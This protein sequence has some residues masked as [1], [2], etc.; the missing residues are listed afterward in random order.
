MRTKVN[1]VLITIFSLSLSLF[2]L[3]TT[4]FGEYPAMVQRGIPLLFAVTL[5][6]LINPLNQNKPLGLSELIPI[7]GA[8]VALG[9]VVVFYEDIGN[10]IGLTTTF[11]TITSIVG[12]IV[13]LEVARR[14]T[15]KILPSLAIVFI[16]YAIFGDLIPGFWGHS[17][18][19]LE[20]IARYIW[21][22]GD[23]VFGVPMEVVVA[24]VIIFV[25][26]AAFLEQSGAG[27]FFIRLS[28]AITGRLRSGPAMSAVAASSLFGTISGSAVANVAATGVFTIPLMKK[29][30]YDP[31]FA[32]ATEAAASTGGQLMP[33][34]MGAGAFVMAEITGT[35]YI[36]ICLAALIP[37]VLYYLGIAMS[38][39]FEAVKKGIQPVPTANVLSISTVLKEGWYFL[40]P[41]F[42]LIIF[43]VNNYTPGRS[44]LMGLL[45][46]IIVGMVKKRL[47]ILDIFKALEKGAQMSLSLIS[48]CATVGVIIGLITL[49]GVGSKF[50]EFVILL[51]RERLFLALILNMIA[52]II[53]GMGVPTVAAYLLLAIVTAPTL[54]K[55]GLPVLTAHLFVYY[56]GVLSAITPPV[57]MA[58]YT[59]ASISG[60]KEM[61]TGLTAVKVALAAF[62]IPYLF[63]YDPAFL[64]TGSLSH[65]AVSFASAAVGIIVLSAATIGFGV[66][67][68]HLVERI[69]LFC[70][71]ILLLKPGLCTDAVGIGLF[72]VFLG[73]KRF[74]VL[75]KERNANASNRV[76][77]E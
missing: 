44:A 7:V 75:K 62:A 35:P 39:H 59:G 26:F 5:I 21:L 57:A 1:Q 73:Y 51:S 14:K 72:F 11:D 23:G 58:A 40:L 42:V 71:S 68:Y 28:Y 50:S 10:R 9:Y 55:L 56:F 49:T 52:S 60:A 19:S 77:I 65:I 37:A 41:I 54:V 61:E 4:I 17:G 24:F 27:D 2:I 74:F 18:F 45:T 15:G 47:S 34:V 46:T 3:Y 67:R 33:P 6:L 25:I 8:W 53:L 76:Q 16:L 38:V 43:L 48:L 12:T 20:R 13:I 36:K 22:S 32:A 29:S 30:G 66:R 64:L 63:A 70:S 69:I 31:S